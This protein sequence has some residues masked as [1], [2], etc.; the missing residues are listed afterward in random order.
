MT[1]VLPFHNRRA[2][3]R[4]FWLTA[5]LVPGILAGALS[6]G[7]P[8]GGRLA[9]GLIVAIFVAVPGLARPDLARR[10][11]RAWNALARRFAR[12]ASAWLTAVSF[13]IVIRAMRGKG[14]SLRLDQPDPGDSLWTPWPDSIAGDV[15]ADGIVAARSSGPGWFRNFVTWARASGNFWGLA[16]LPMLLLLSA[17]ETSEDVEEPPPGIYTLY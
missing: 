17:F 1:I 7:L 5:S 8:A 3:L 4:S 11:M 2:W 15:L 14:S 9:V 6:R 12:A 16:L 10:P 13:H